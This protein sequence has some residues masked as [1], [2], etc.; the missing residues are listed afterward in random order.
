MEENVLDNS[1]YSLTLKY[2]EKG[3]Y[4]FQS[5]SGTGKTYLYKIINLCRHWGRP[6]SAYSC[7]DLSKGLRPLDICKPTDRIVMFDRYDMYAGQFD[8]EIRLL[9]E[10]TSVFL[11]TK[12]AA[13]LPMRY[14]LCTLHFE[15][16]S[17]RIVGG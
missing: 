9:A 8:E 3:L 7:D 15:P 12:T 11:D 13:G 17:F 1:Q 10:K 6:V 2:I 14:C 4:V 16:N 5:E